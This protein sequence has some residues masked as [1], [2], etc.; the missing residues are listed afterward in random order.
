MAAPKGPMPLESAIPNAIASEES[1]AVV[2]ENG[3]TN[4]IQDKEVS[5]E[6]LC[7]ISAYDQWTPLSVSGQLPRPRYKHGAAVVQQKMY[8]FGGNHNGR[9][10]GDIQ[11][12][13][14]K[15]LLW[16]KLEAKSQSGLSESA[17]TVSVAACAGH[18]LIPWGNKI[19]SLAGHTRDPTESL[20]VK[21]FDPRT[22]TWSTL[23]TYG[24]SPSSRGGQ[25][26]T[27]V[28]N[29]LIVFG[30][31]GAGR[32][33]L[34]DLHILDL[35]TM[36]WDEFETTGTLPSPRSE[37]AAACYAERYLL[38]FGGG[39]HSTCFSD[40]H[41]L[42]THAME[43]SRPEQQGIIPEPR[44]GHAGVAIGENWFI[45]G[46]GNNTKGVPDTLVLNMST[47][48]WSIVIS[49]E[50]RN[51]PT[52]E[53]SS[54]VPH[55][56]SGEDFLVSFGGY[57]GRYSNEV[58]AL[59]PSLKPSLRPSDPAQQINEPETNGIAPISVVATS[60]RKAIFEIEELQDE[61]GSSR[62]NISKTLVQAV[63]GERN[64]VED[65]LYQER[66]QKLRLKQELADVE[67]R[68]V[69]LAKELD[70]VQD[71]LSAEGVRASKLEND[72]SELQQRLQKMNALEY[73]FE[74]LHREMDAASEEAA[75][76]SNQPPR[77]GGFWRWNG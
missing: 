68:N 48:V 44:A 21:E 62:A 65:G 31:E 7:Y 37:H 52:S 73:E 36:T 59:K 70:L 27:L 6:G 75:S 8:I 4:D 66:L 32:T 39:S 38:I 42:D 1:K 57:S 51:P 77:G 71:Q 56:I 26:V 76:S 17:E 15:S 40:L 69:E 50:G 29:T 46:G 41:L 45:T 74:S 67:D 28:G 14:L 13:D 25:S 9:Y 12:L 24:R 43:W 3:K 18:S 64:Q 33:L 55:T 20:S 34:N 54:L 23:R 61:K 47:Y 58:Y 2:A 22:C 35:E 11:V 19:L 53:G 16:S 63:K 49:S 72:I 5:M 60:S 10:L 30:G